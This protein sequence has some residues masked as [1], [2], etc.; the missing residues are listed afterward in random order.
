MRF[1]AA[2]EATFPS[3]LFRGKEEA[4]VRGALFRVFERDVIRGGDAIQGED[5][6]TPTLVFFCPLTKPRAKAWTV[7][8][9]NYPDLGIFAFS[10]SI[11]R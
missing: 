10:T 2:A 8:R 7:R 5:K 4:A 3:G 11:S 1:P 6:A 9:D